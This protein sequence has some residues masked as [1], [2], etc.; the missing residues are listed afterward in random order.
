MDMLWHETWGCFLLLL[1][2][3]S[4]P[5]WIQAIGAVLA[6]VVAI[7]VPYRQNKNSVRERRASMLA[8]AEAAHTHAKKIRDAIDHSDF[9]QGEISHKIYDV[10]DKSII[11]G[12][13]GAL[14]RVPLH[15]LGSR[16]AVIAWLSMTDQMVFLGTSVDAFIAGPYQ[17]PGLRESL[18]NH[19]KHD[20]NPLEKRRQLYAQNFNILA[21]NA[22]CHL[23]I[24][25]LD[26]QI[27]IQ[28][29]ST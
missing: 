16:D 26:Y 23:D 4:A 11:V 24:I 17:Y 28:S 20:P 21:K 6:L 5:S 15:E 12:V 27:L 14:Q 19:A 1:K 25:D 2:D 3:P 10:Y 13:V 7:L 8:V 22:K 29:V 9:Q 18:E